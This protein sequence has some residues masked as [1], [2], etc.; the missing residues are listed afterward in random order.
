LISAIRDV[1]ER[2]LEENSE[3]RAAADM[4]TIAAIFA[5]EVAN[6]LNGIYT[7]LEFIKELVPAEN[8]N[9]IASLS[10][11]FDR[12]RSMLDQFRSL[13][14]LTDLK[15]ELV[16]F[17]KI[18]G[19]VV[20]MNSLYWLEQ[21]IRTVT[22][23]SGDLNLT[24]DADKLLQAILN[25]TANAVESM[26][27]GGILTLTAYSTGEEV[28]FEVSDT[29]SGIPEGVDVFKPFS[30]TKRQGSGKDVHCAAVVS[31]HLNY[32]L[33]TNRGR[34][35]VQFTLPMRNVKA[36]PEDVDFAFVTP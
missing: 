7:T 33:F 15:L 31:A 20:K 14:R 8:Q 3:R 6:P 12:L 13:S 36:Y 30:T 17:A 28:I 24:G 11:E 22:D 35:Y 26:P 5:H 32:Y 2:K 4:G 27:D 23:F 25:L 34:N 1:T 9:L 18:V 19:H 16:D 29:G 10:T 21:G